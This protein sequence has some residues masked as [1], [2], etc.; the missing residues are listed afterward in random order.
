MKPTRE[1]ATRKATAVAAARALVK[2]HVAWLRGYPRRAADGAL[3]WIARDGAEEPID[4][5]RLARA[6]RALRELER[7]YAS[8]LADVLPDGASTVAALARVVESLKPA[9]HGGA[10]LPD[11]LGLELASARSAARARALRASRPDLTRIVD[12]LAFIEASDRKRFARTLDV[13]ADVPEQLLSQTSVD[14]ATALVSAATDAGTFAA[15]LPLA[16]ALADPRASDILTAEHQLVWRTMQAKATALPELTS[17]PRSW[18]GELE[19]LAQALAS[20]SERARAKALFAVDVLDIPSVFDE[21]AAFWRKIDQALRTLARP[22]S[23]VPPSGRGAYLTKLRDAAPPPVSAKET[24][25]TILFYANASPDLSRAIER[26]LRALGRDLRAGVLLQHLTSLAR[27]NEHRA[28]VVVD[29]LARYLTKTRSLGEVRLGPFRSTWL[30]RRQSASYYVA[31]NDLLDEPPRVIARFFDALVTTVESH[32][33]TGTVVRDDV[34]AWLIELTLANA[35]AALAARVVAHPGLPRGRYNTD[36][37]KDALAIAEDDPER[38][39]TVIE[40]ARVLGAW[41]AAPA[42]ALLRPLVARGEARVAFEVIAGGGLS[43]LMSASTVLSTLGCPTPLASFHGRPD[44]A[45]FVNDYPDVLHDALRSLARVVPNAERVAKRILRDHARDTAAIDDEIRALRRLLAQR[46]DPS[47]AHTE[48]LRA[49]LANLTRRRRDGARFT[50]KKAA[51]LEKKIARATVNEIVAHVTEAA[52]AASRRFVCELLDVDSV[53]DDW[54][55]PLRQRL[56]API[57]TLEPKMRALAGRVLR[58]RLGPPPWDLR[59][60]PENRAFI[61]RLAERGVDV[62]PWRAPAAPPER[63]LGT[64]GKPFFLQLEDDP[65]VVMEMG[66]HFDTCLAPDGCNYFSVFANAADVNKRVLYARDERGRIVARA[67]LALT[68]AGGIVTFNP[69]A[70]AAEVGWPARVGAFAERLATQMGTVVLP[71]GEVPRLVAPDWYDDGPHD[72]TSRFAF[73]ESGS[74]L[75]RGIADADARPFMAD[76]AAR[77]APLPINE[78]VLPLV[79]ALPEIESNAAI[80]T[81]L[82][83]RVRALPLL[84]PQTLVRA[85]SLA[86][87]FERRD[88]VDDDLLARIERWG[89]T[90][91]AAHHYLSL[92]VLSVLAELAPRRALVVLRRARPRGVRTWDAD[93]DPARA[94][95]AGRAL[96]GLQ[97]RTQAL[98]HYRRGARGHG[99]EAMKQACK[100]RARALEGA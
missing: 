56:L 7:D 87:R 63:F 44:R 59:D 79:L 62:G 67:L 71:R 8:V 95:Y 98:E 49:R 83:V 92:D 64:D 10:P 85:A 2:A 81:E 86:M 91:Y 6:T 57:A 43:T 18:R 89:L 25:D 73:L 12:A 38:F 26:A 23:E 100:E 32:A 94:Y 30:A 4:G 78:L 55:T 36:L 97:R 22:D 42:V 13:L 69:Y 80:V 82:L 77:V 99:L 17:R 27:T 39:A 33:R 50:A 19:R 93:Q 37:V 15:T 11:P 28:V 9:V 66:L 60:A 40:A 31:E 1:R 48:R 51:A 54:T 46:S 14:V 90:L 3:L 68:Q 21:W 76:L 96:E 70:H 20:L 74:E 61:E 52:R 75:R 88:L 41:Q 45:A 35:P 5:R 84:P 24:V 34:N 29:G 53:P 58:A 47:R 72:L 65:L 16:T